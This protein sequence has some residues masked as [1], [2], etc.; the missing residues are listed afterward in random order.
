M[1]NESKI[2]GSGVIWDLRDLYWGVDDP[3]IEADRLWCRDEVTRFAGFYAGRVARLSPESLFAAVSSLESIEEVCERI[4]SFAYLSF[5]TRTDNPEMSRF[6]QS[7]QGFETEIRG[8]SLFFTLEWS[9]LSDEQALMFMVHPALKSYRHYLEQ[10]RRF[11]P[12]RLSGPEEQILEALSLSGSKAWVSLFDKVVSSI[13]FGTHGRPLSLVLADLHH[14]ERESRREASLELAAGLD[15]V[16]HILAHIYNTVSLD[17]SIRDGL[18]SYPHWLRKLNLCNEISDEQV[19]TLARAVTGRYD[20]VRNYYVLKKRILQYAELYDYD[21]YAPLPG[22]PRKKFTWQQAKEIVLSAYHDFSPEMAEVSA[23]FFERGWIHAA[24]L[25]GKS[26]GAF[27]HP[28]VPSCHPYISLNFTGTYRDILT[29]AHEL[30]HG[31]HQYLSRRQGLLNSR[32]PLTMAEIASVFGEM[33]VFQCLLKKSASPDEKLAILCSKLE[34]IMTTTFRQIAL[35]SFEKAVHEER[36]IS[37]ELIP[38]RLSSLWL[39][40]QQE[41]YGKSLLLQDHYR[42]WWAYIPHF[43]RT[44]GYVYAYAFAELTALSLFERYRHEGSTFV[45]A[46]MELLENGSR[47][48]PEDLLKSVGIDLAEPGFFDRGLRMVEELM[49]EASQHTGDTSSLP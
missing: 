33:L 23:L 10:L 8:K 45:P 1:E 19:A 36:H 12:H 35:H 27:S 7:A 31:I 22:L 16:L 5:I 47:A 40:T 14:Q 18:L 38:E 15:G 32:I 37:G 25:Q 30:G 20:M 2:I 48:S 17:M 24:V 42:T 29:L 28:T 4:L 43:V 41:M 21:R 6:W 9:R 26:S 13:R 49:E 39:S 46:Y 3:Q 11:R 44:P 34:E